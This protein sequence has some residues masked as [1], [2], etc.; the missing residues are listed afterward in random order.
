MNHKTKTMKTRIKN[1][2]TLTITALAL[3]F[4]PKASAQPAGL[5]WAEMSLSGGASRVPALTTNVIANGLTS[6][7][8]YGLPGTYSNLCM[9]VDEFD[10]VGFTWK[11]GAGSNATVQVFKSMDNQVTYEAIPSFSFSGP[12]TSSGAF[13]TNA[14]L[15]VHGVSHLAFVLKNASTIDESNALVEINL[16]SPKFGAKQATQ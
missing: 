12:A 10:Y 14:L 7:N 5:H 8:I 4:A 11:Y 16:K 6:T 2:A 1:F 3:A 13:S 15:D 9:S